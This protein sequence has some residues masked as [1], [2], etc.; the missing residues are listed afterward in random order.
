MK[1][2]DGRQGGQD[3]GQVG[4]A[5]LEGVLTE[6]DVADPVQALQSPVAADIV[7]EVAAGCL[8][9]G[10]A[11]DAQAADVGWCSVTA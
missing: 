6:G 2:A 10:R 5:D 11:S 7:G 1:C 3:V 4:G 8:W 9:W